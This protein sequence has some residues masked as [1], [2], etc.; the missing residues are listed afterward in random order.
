MADNI[1]DVEE[2]AKQ[3]LCVRTIRKLKIQS[4]LSLRS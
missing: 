1:L 3:R 2:G 4:S